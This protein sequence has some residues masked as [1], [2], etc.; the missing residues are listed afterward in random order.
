MEGAAANAALSVLAAAAGTAPPFSFPT[1]AAALHRA[2]SRLALL[3]MLFGLGACAPTDA[4][5]TPVAADP[6]PASFVPPPAAPDPDRRAPPE[7]MNHVRVEAQRRFGL[8][9]SPGDGCGQVIVPDRAFLPVELTGDAAPEW[10]VSFGRASCGV[11]GNASLWTGT[12]GPLIQVW[13]A[14]PT[15]ELLLETAMHG[16]SV[17]GGRLMTQQHG[18]RCPGG[19]GPNICLV[20]YVWEPATQ[21]LAVVREVFVGNDWQGDVPTPELGY[22]VLTR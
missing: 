22:E 20:D 14:G 8:E 4:M 2:V 17:T 12:G 1:A 19:A 10:V 9:P 5:M 13:R 21:R 15:P 3:M 18:A 7:L 11:G 6:A 16:F